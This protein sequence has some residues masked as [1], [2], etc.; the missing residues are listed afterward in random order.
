MTGDYKIH[1]AKY[2]YVMNIILRISQYIFPLITIPYITRTL[3][4]AANGKVSFAVSMISYFAMFAQLGIPSYGIRECAKCRDDKDELTKTVQEL[5]VINAVST[6]LTYIA[7]F[8][9]LETVPRLRED[10]TLFLILS[11]SMLLNTVGMDW[12]YQAIEQYQYITARNIAFKVISIALMFLLVHHPEDYVKYGFL[13]LVG[14]YGSNILNLWNS[15]KIL[16]HKCY[17]GEYTFARHLK[18]VMIFFSQSVAVSIYTN[19]DT[20]MLGFLSTDTEV[21]FYAL[22]TKVRMVVASTVSAIGPV[23]LPRVTHCLAHAEYDKVRGYL[24]KG[25]HF[26]ILSAVPFTVFFCVTASQVIWILGGAEYAP[27]ALCMQ[28]VNLTVIPLGVGTIAISLVLV[29]TNREIYVMYATIAGA[30]TDFVLNWLFIPSYG[31]AGAAFATVITEIAVAAI[32]VCFGW[33]MIRKV[34]FK[35]PYLKLAVSN[36]LAAVV[37]WFVA[38]FLSEINAII[39][40][41]IAAIIYFGFYGII[42][43]LQK[44]SLAVEIFAV[45]RSRVQRVRGDGSE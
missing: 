11:V 29:P 17:R 5:L 4:A 41:V 45:T 20:V 26:V 18:P 43:L 8:I 33:K 23:L 2:N 12:L 15:R 27:A 25:F 30:V 22:G 42:L 13:T 7:L 44:D 38:H 40:L 37:L 31:A 10:T 24:K 6:A 1:S 19:L 14:N 36:I 21:A 34:F 9:A 32:Q 3:G 16:L 35:V 39:Y 28:I